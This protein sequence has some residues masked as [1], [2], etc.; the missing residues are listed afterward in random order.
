VDFGDPVHGGEVG[1][2]VGDE[3][4][5][6]GPLAG[7]AGEEVDDGGASL[8]VEGAGGLVGQEDGGVVH[9]GAGDVDALAL[10]AGELMRPPLGLTGEAAAPP[11]WPPPPNSA[12]SGGGRAP[13]GS[14]PFERAPSCILNCRRRPAG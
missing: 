12:S 4:G 11:P 6:G 3:D 10:A 8:V 1:A 9:Q 7:E 14:V 2:V 13:G 5:R